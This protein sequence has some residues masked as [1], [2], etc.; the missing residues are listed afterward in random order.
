MGC[1][2][3]KLFDDMYLP[4]SQSPISVGKKKRI[5]QINDEFTRE[6]LIRRLFHYYYAYN[7][8][9]LRNPVFIRSLLYSHNL[10]LR[11]ATKYGTEPPYSEVAQ[12]AYIRYIEAR[13]FNLYSIY[14]SRIQ[15]EGTGFIHTLIDYYC[16]REHVLIDDIVQKYGPEPNLISMNII[17]PH[18][19]KSILVNIEIDDD[20]KSSSDDDNVFVSEVERVSDNE[21][22]ELDCRQV[23]VMNPVCKEDQTQQEQEKQPQPEATTYTHELE[24]KREETIVAP[25]LVAT[26]IYNPCVF[27]QTEQNE[28]DILE[29]DEIV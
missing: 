16:N 18:S 21:V 22:I 24:T 1:A 13:V 11:L 25:P 15:E 17:K 26:K 28:W 10:F 14:T 12:K 3:C 7:P 6:I 19:H 4:S 29:A 8:D 5:S 2:L 9:K 27:I 23:C 20:N